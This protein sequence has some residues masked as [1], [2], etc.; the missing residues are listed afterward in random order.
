LLAFLKVPYYLWRITA[1]SGLNN[2]TRL[3]NRVSFFIQHLTRRKFRRLQLVYKKR[4]YSTYFPISFVYRVLISL[5]S[6]V[7]CLFS[8]II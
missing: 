5:A 4:P 8:N 7:Q 2:Q 3:L 1:K 6:A